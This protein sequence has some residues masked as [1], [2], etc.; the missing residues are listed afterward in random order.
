MIMSKHSKWAKIKNDKGAAD[1][2]KGAMFTKHSR[3][4]SVAARL[5]GDPE[6]NF[7]LRMAM[8]AAKTA[9]VP[10]DTIER[11]VTRGSGGAGEEELAEML[12]EAIGPG[13]VGIMIEAVTN[14]KN[15]TVNDLR[16]LLEEYGGTLANSGAVAWQFQRLGVIRLNAASCH[17]EKQTEACLPA[18]RN[19]LSTESLELK[20]IDLGAEDIKEEEGGLTIYTK[21]ESFQKL[22]DGLRGLNLAPEY[23]GLEWVAKEPMAVNDASARARL[24]EL[25]AALDADDDTQN[26]FTSEA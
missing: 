7:K 8:D 3:A 1:V 19:P 16:R 18:G 20:L 12:Y 25:Y 15:R 23:S 4:I 9:G 21:Q 10:K 24:D 22:L 17:S 5:G 13:K 2:K 11:A 6:K 26:Y 14:N